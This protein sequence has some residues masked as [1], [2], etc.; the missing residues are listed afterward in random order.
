MTVRRHISYLLVTSLVLLALVACSG[1]SPSAEIVPSSTPS[2]SVRTR[3]VLVLWHAWPSPD[4]RALAALAERYN[5]SHP[6]VQIVLQSHPVATITTDMF[7]AVAEGGGPHM[8]ILKSHTLGGLAE[9]GA[10]LPID[11]LLPESDLSRLL[12]AALGAAQITSP[13]GSVL[14]GVPVT[15][16]TLALYYNKANFAIAPPA[17]TS[18][19]LSVARGL[20]DTRSD[21]PTWGLALNLSLDR[22]IGYLYAFDGRVFDDERAL[23]LGLDGRVGTE[24]WLT[25]LEALHS[26]KRILAS[27]DGIAIDNALMSR[28]AL[29]TFD[30]SYALMAYRD[31]WQENLGVAPLPRLSDG[32]RAP[33]PYVQS[34]LVVLN[35]RIGV[36]ERQAAV[37][38]IRYLISAESQASLLQAGRQPALI[39]LDLAAVEGVTPQIREAALV[40]RRQAEQGLPMPN[41]REANEVVWD[42]LSTMH[43]NALRRLLSPAQ[44]VSDAD[45]AL[46]QRLDLPPAP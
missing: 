40:F 5:R 23:V 11:D 8:A 15:F 20:T 41:S 46:R 22:T 34:D 33:Q 26:D 16:D 18:A 17:D 2:S 6:A 7:L 10:I 13:T 45:S 42:V 39:S 44:A 38:F 3:T 24:A 31:L 21:P 19:L 1:G 30:W 12:P 28:E 32:D 27:T 35:A 36:V 14:Y 29:M 43:A 9:S 37:D 4:D 25:W